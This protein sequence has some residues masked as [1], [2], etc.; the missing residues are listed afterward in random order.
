MF[1]NFLRNKIVPEFAM[2]AN[3]VLIMD[4]AKIHNASSVLQ[5]CRDHS[6]AVKFMVP[7][8]PQLNPTEEFF[9]MIK[10]RY[11]AEKKN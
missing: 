2:N 4:N 11:K 8:S 7:Y 3:K 9:A 1:I 6:I 10:A 5:F